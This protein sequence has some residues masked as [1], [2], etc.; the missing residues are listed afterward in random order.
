MSVE[1]S[2]PTQSL[3]RCMR[4]HINCIEFG[5]P[6]ASIAF[7]L[8]IPEKYEMEITFSIRA[9]FS[10]SSAEMPSFPSIRAELH[11]CRVPDS[12]YFARKCL[13]HLLSI[14]AV[15]NTLLNSYFHYSPFP[16]SL[17]LS[18]YLL[19]LRSIYHP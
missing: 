13:P 6:W 17:P 16:K 10:Q 1:F 12:P 9:F 15:G 14:A 7:V 3:Q 5:R 11:W 19:F 8:N 4:L 2:L 18:H